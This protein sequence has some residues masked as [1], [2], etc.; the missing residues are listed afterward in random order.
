MVSGLAKCCCWCEAG[1]LGSGYLTRCLHLNITK[2]YRQFFYEWGTQ[3]LKK[4]TALIQTQHDHSEKEPCKK[5]P[6]FLAQRYFGGR[7]SL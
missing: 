7:A 4:V 6:Q 1:I 5:N 3:R 2:K